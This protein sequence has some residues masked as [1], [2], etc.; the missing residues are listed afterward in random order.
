MCVAI[1]GHGLRVSDPIMLM[2][3][4]E[5]YSSLTCT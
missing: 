5:L 4:L 2:L 1:V 3:L